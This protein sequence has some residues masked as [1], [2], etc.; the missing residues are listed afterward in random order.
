MDMDA[1]ALALALGLGLLGFIEP[2]TI[3]AH[4]LFLGAQRARTMRQRLGAM[5]VFLAARLAVTGGFGGLIVVLGRILID[6]QTGAWLAFGVIYL[7][8]FVPSW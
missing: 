3:G 8:Y 1:H 7:C 6:V 2:C 4:M 5:A